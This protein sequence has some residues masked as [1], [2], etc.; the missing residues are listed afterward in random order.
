M[1]TSIV[2]QPESRAVSRRASPRFMVTSANLINVRLNYHLY[3]SPNNAGVM[4]VVELLRTE[5]SLLGAGSAELGVT[6]DHFLRP[7][8]CCFLVLLDRV[9]HTSTTSEALQGE[10]RCALE[11][12]MP[13]LLVHEQ[14]PSRDTS[15]AFKFLFEVVD[16]RDVTPAALIRLG[17]YAPM[18]TPLYDGEHGKVSARLIL[19]AL[20]QQVPFA[21][22]SRRSS[23][24]SSLGAVA[25]HRLHRKKSRR[26]ELL[27]EQKSV[28]LASV[29]LSTSI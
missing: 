4:E 29:R 2:G 24:R 11:E 5:S 12:G 8:A 16:G 21:E 23:R 1:V 20:C 9:T 17:I 3:A 6:T 28:Q 14:R 7:Q 15:V 18:A 27:E 22:S 25:Q 26:E 10:L 13:L 19:R